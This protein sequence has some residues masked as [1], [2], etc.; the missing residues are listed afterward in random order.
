MGELPPELKDLSGY[1][2]FD[3]EELLKVWRNNFKGIQYEK[4]DYLF[5][6]AVDNILVKDDVLVVLDYK[7]RGYPVKEDTH[8]HY[9]QQME[10]YNYLLRKN[11]YKTK[12][13]TY[14]L[15]YHPLKVLE[16]GCVDFHAEL[17]K[18]KTD[19]K[20]AEAVFKRAI[21]ILEGDAPTPSE[22]CEYCAYRT[23]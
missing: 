5:R 3:D 12:D 20:K 17:I 18:I 10:I 9:I 21:K 6:G 22:G 7:T 4:G 2:L 8:E 11:N 1:K 23:K 14:L 15:F 16:N 19:V 13:Y